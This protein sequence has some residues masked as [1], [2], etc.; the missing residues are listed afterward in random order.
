MK[1]LISFG[2]GHSLGCL[3]D[4]EE[5]YSDKNTYHS[6][7]AIVARCN[8]LEYTHYGTVYAS[9]ESIFRMVLTHITQLGNPEDD[10]I[11]IN[12]TSPDRTE[13]RYSDNIAADFKW[14]GK[15]V[16]N[17]FYTVGE[18]TYPWDL[19]KSVNKILKFSNVLNNYGQNMTQFGNYVLTLQKTLDSLG[20]NWIM[21]NTTHNI[22]LTPFNSNLIKMTDH[23]R[24]FQEV[25]LKSVADENKF[26]KTACGHYKYDTHSRF[27]E[28]IDHYI[29]ENHLV[30]GKH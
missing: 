3:I 26:Y 16:D 20:Y 30:H 10:F 1:N 12:W 25:S 19:D 24:Y 13:L 9:N 17:K 23:K 27:A 6:F 4:D 5:Y 14:I 8:A 22:M 15:I 2:C 28:A 7:P 29:K 18:K 21:V 11:M